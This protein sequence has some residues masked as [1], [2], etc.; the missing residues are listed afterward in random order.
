MCDHTFIN[1]FMT[2]QILILCELVL[3]YYEYLAHTKQCDICYSYQ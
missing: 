3:K 1:Y 2:E